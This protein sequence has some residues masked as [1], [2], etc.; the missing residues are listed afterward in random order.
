MAVGY[1]R[2]LERSSSLNHFVAD[3]HAAAGMDV[4]QDTA[5]VEGALPRQLGRSAS[6]DSVNSVSHESPPVSSISPG[7]SGSGGAECVGNTGTSVKVDS[8]SKAPT[9]QSDSSPPI[10]T[11]PLAGA[12][13]LSSSRRITVL[14]QVGKVK[15]KRGSLTKL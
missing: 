14:S 15:G 9:L 1:V 13:G 7:H 8:R 3:I 5:L 4:S 2:S 6:Q 11:T 10:P 12:S